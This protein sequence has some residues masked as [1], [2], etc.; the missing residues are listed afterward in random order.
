MH[1]VLAKPCLHG[2]RL[3]YSTLQCVFVHGTYV[4]LDMKVVKRH[5]LQWQPGVGAGCSG[6]PYGPLQLPASQEEPDLA[7]QVADHVI[8]HHF[9]HLQGELHRSGGRSLSHAQSESRLAVACDW[10]VWH[11]ACVVFCCMC[12]RSLYSCYAPWQTV[13]AQYARSVS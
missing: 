10:V 9:S 11:P 3:Q 5:I 12:A 2:G 8:K 6:V 13:S 7:R 1:L 4:H